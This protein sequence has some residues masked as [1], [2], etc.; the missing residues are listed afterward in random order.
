MSPL[1]LRIKEFSRTRKVLDSDDEKCV[2]LHKLLDAWADAALKLETALHDTRLQA[3]ARKVE[4][5]DLRR[6]RD[7]FR[8]DGEMSRGGEA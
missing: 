6:Q 8:A 7:A 4:A 3:A 5:D 2:V 1:S